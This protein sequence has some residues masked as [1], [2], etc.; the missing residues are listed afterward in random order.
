MAGQAGTGLIG[1]VGAGGLNAAGSG[2]LNA[3]GAGSASNLAG[4]A[5][6]GTFLDKFMESLT[7]KD[8]VIGGFSALQ[9][10][11]AMMEKNTASANR[12]KQY[13]YEQAQRNQRISN[14]NSVP[15]LRNS[16]DAN[17]GL[18]ANAGL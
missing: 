13:E 8:Y 14:L 5:S 6:S 7:P 16:L 2:A 9:G 4:A 11:A 18:N 15:T 17:T 10:G 3:I 12:Q 1:Q